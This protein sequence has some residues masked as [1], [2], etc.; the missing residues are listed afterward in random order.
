MSKTGKKRL[1]FSRGRHHRPRPPTETAHEPPSCLPFKKCAKFNLIR[2]PDSDPPL[3]PSLPPSFSRSPSL[4]LTPLSRQF[5]LVTDCRSSSGRLPDVGSPIVATIALSRSLTRFAD[6]HGKPS[7]S[8]K[9]RCSTSR[10][11]PPTMLHPRF[12]KQ[13]CTKPTTHYPHSRRAS[14]ANVWNWWNFCSAPS[15]CSAAV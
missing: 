15:I 12:S 2:S 1:P 13:M 4:C 5:Y 3:P 14:S 11:F 8:Q 7:E 6:M 9:G 10:F